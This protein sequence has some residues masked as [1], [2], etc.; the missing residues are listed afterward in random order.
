MKGI[1]VDLKENELR[2]VRFRLL[3]GEQGVLWLT[4]RDGRDRLLR[5]GEFLDSEGGKT[6]IQGIGG[7][8]SLWIFR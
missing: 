3:K 5:A 4:G 1:R 2:W 7:S 6:L 8:C